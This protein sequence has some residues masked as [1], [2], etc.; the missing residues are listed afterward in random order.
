MI[1]A[2]SEASKRDEYLQRLMNLPNQVGFLLTD[3]LLIHLLWSPRKVPT[4]QEL[5][6]YRSLT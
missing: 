4:L 5:P 2:E 1:Q 6:E 3:T